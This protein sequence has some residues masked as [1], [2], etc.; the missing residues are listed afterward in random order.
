MIY[1]F[2]FNL[3]CN[4][5]TLSSRTTRNLKLSLEVESPLSPRVKGFEIEVAFEVEVE[6]EPP[7]NYLISPPLPYII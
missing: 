2:N 3:S 7:Y 5:K 4:F 6:K 1:N